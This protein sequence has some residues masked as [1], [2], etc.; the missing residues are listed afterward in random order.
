[1]AHNYPPIYKLPA[2]G[3]L[4]TQPIGLAG[5]EQVGNYI[6]HDAKETKVSQPRLTILW[7]AYGVNYGE[8]GFKRV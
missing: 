8:F 1:M 3:T 2:P 4:S 5:R 7:L 6:Y